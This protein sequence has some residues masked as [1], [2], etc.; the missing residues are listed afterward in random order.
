MKLALTGKTLL[1]SL[2][3]GLAIVP[4]LI[5]EVKGQN[6]QVTRV[7]NFTWEVSQSYQPPDRSAPST[8]AGGAS[9]GSCLE[10]TGVLTSLMPQNNLGLTATGYPTFFWYVPKSS[11]QAL[12][13][14]LRDSTNG[15]VVYQKSLPV[16][17]NSG[18]VSFTLTKNELPA[19]LEVGKLYH[20]YFTMVC[21]PN[22]N[23][24]LPGKSGDVIVDGW[25]ERTELNPVLVNQLENAAP[26][27]RPALYAAAGIWHDS[28]T[29]LVE[30]L[31]E[32]PDDQNLKNQWKELL[33][34]VGL[35]SIAEKQIIDCCISKD[36]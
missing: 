18:I 6:Q 16:P 27:D 21:P 4:N 8:T 5:A 9:R 10:S 32:K 3:L 11:A 14:K 20:W 26:S 34:S 17:E 33:N 24:E 12:E 25:V 29:I 1:V 7:K 35:N 23:E 36:D 22:P 13:F 31:R 2:S 19:P 30:L 15:E 28:L